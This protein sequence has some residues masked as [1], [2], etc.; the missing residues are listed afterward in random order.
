MR[1][2]IKYF[3][4]EITFMAKNSSQTKK[5]EQCSRHKLFLLQQEGI[6][7]LYQKK[8]NR[9]LK[10][11][12]YWKDG[13]ELQITNAIHKATNEVELV[14]LVKH[15]RKEEKSDGLWLNPSQ[16]KEIR[17]EIQQ[18]LDDQ[19]CRGQREN[20]RANRIIKKE[21]KKERLECGK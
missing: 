11:I 9:Y 7:D 8:L 5:A 4:V 14:K 15:K 21:L 12:E 16:R 3:P 18:I 6:K 13:T 2:Y 19:K 10:S 1:W 17:K 20:K